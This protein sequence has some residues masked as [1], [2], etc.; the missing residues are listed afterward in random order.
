MRRENLK[1]RLLRAVSG[2]T[3]EQVSEEI[4]DQPGLI[5]QIEQGKVVARHDYLERLAASD[6]L[7]AA[8]AEEFLCLSET[9]RASRRRCGRSAKDLL[10]GLA[11][12]LRSQ[13]RA[14]YERLLTLPHPDNPPR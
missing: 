4:G 12:D 3:Q 10:E 11:E 6:G 14:S 5:A 8:D 13:T 7:T 2:K 1:A 9:L